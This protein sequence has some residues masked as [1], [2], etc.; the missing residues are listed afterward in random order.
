[1][2]VVPVVVVLEG[3]FPLL[4]QPPPHLPFVFILLWPI[5]TEG[6]SLGVQQALSEGSSSPTPK[7]LT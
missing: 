2:V 4:D 3:T 5:S 6:L 7:F 1:M